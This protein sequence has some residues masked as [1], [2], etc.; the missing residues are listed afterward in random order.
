MIYQCFQC[1]H[2]KWI[3]Y[4]TIVYKQVL[5]CRKYSKWT[6]IHAYCE[7]SHLMRNRSTKRNKALISLTTELGGMLW[8]T[9][10]NVIILKLQR[11]VTVL[12]KKKISI[13]RVVD[14]RC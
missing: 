3:M 14:I 2:M 6:I 8:L 13:N 4:D 10:G 1:S 9:S 12:F 11:Y 7:D 5:Y